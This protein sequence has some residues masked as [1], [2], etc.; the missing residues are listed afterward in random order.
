M[1]DYK[2]MSEWSHY[3]EHKCGQV[4]RVPFG[5]LAFL[6]NFGDLCQG[7]GESMDFADL[8]KFVGKY[9]M[10]GNWYNPLSWRYELQRKS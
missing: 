7:C 1:G 2:I 3:A 5:N 8:D 6:T 9:V 10:V 4:H